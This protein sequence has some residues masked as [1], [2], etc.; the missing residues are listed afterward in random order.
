M[1]VYYCKTEKFE[2]CYEKAIS[3]LS[4]E[5][6][7]KTERYLKKE[8]KLLSLT[9][10]LM[11]RKVF[12]EDYSEKIKYNEHGKPFFEHGPCFS[13]S[14]SKNIA[15][16]AVSENNIGADIEG[17]KAVSEAVIKRCFTEEEQIY[18]FL[19]TQNTLYVWTAKEAV[20]KLLGCGFSFSPKNFSVLPFEEKHEIKRAKIG[21]IRTEICKIPLTVAYEGEENE[22]EILEFQPEDLI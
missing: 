7:E 3:L 10:G 21:F 9:T 16:L 11:L 20:L 12:G 13:V 18:A 4:Q 14:H 2:H 15:I 1:K 17:A 6:R 5:R 19:S 8:D 22:A